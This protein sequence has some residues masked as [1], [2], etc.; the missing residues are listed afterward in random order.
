MVR[1]FLIACL[2]TLPLACAASPSSSTAVADAAGLGA[3]D[4]TT[5]DSSGADAAPD[6]AA[7]GPGAP[8]PYAGTCP[9]VV[10]GGDNVIS[11]AGFNRHYRV[12]LPPDPTGAPLV[13]LWHGLGDTAKNFA[14]SLKATKLA[15]K[16]GVIAVVPAACSENP[17]NIDCEP[18]LLTWDSDGSHSEDAQLF[19]DVLACLDQAY[20]IDRQRVYTA[21][22]S[23]GALWSTWLLMHRADRLAAAVVFS[24]GVKDG[25][26]PY[27]TPAYKLP[28]LVAWGGDID[29]YANG[30]I[31]FFDTSADLRKD[32][33]KDGHF[34]L[35]CNHGLG[36]TV[37]PGGLQFGLE[38]LLAHTWK[39]GSS[40]FATGPL[41]AVFP[42]YCTV[43][44]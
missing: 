2:A 34:V 44:P 12:Y 1:R 10:D 26:I 11:S 30:I 6:V 37:P 39:D 14:T 18:G 21:G 23:A 22:F 40:P 36:H 13:F 19:D 7:P 15:E 42:D 27:V 3:A 5:A 35:A 43:D 29:T 32:L 38:F 28:V 16:Y 31:D 20:S 41:P 25:M 24:G 8:T 17:A 4:A 33:R 9:G